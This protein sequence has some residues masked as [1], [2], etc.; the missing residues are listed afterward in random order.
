MSKAPSPPARF[1]PPRKQKLGDH[2]YE[3]LLQ[4]IVSGQLP[5]GER[6]PSEPALAAALGV[7]RPV[8]REALSR[9]RADGVVT[10]RH[11]SGTYVERRPNPEFLRLA[12]IGGVAD[13]MRCFEF[14]V[15][16]EG[17][18]AYLAAQRR[19]T[20]DLAA[21]NRALAALDKAIKQRTLGADADLR[22]HTAIANAARNKLFA[23]TLGALHAQV[24]AGMKVARNLSLKASVERL[25]IVQEEH[26]RIYQAISDE[27]PTEARESMRLHI[28]NARTRLL[29]D[30]AEP[31]R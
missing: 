20:D 10:S 4:R 15:G 8:V 13:L 12:P 29:S 25:H 7:S 27:N 18:A 1:A 5:E 31:V 2:V 19:G 17:E 14:R 16:V 30:S 24:F 22:F 28:L 26:R 23:T 9:L 3:Q 6:L 11:G 21:M